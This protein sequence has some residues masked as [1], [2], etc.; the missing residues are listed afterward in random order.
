[1]AA[2]SHD[3]AGRPTLERHN[4]EVTAEYFY[5]RYPGD[6]LLGLTDNFEWEGYPAYAV[7]IGR[8]VAVKDRSGVTIS[9]ADYGSFSESW[10]Q[11]YPDDRI[12]HFESKVNYAGELIYSEDPD[13]AR[14]YAD[15][16]ES[17]A[18]KGTATEVWRN[19][20]WERKQILADAKYNYLG[21]AELLT[22]GTA[23]RPRCGTAST[24]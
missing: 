13:G 9:A 12:Y 18:L 10:K 22:Y 2:Y 3:L 23:E 16:Y 19:G 20:G 5:D 11:V 15:Y 6:D 4:G 1:M 7:T 17:G 21:Q 8:G 14:S 24:R